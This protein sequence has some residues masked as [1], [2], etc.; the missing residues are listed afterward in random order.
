MRSL[1]FQLGSHDANSFSE[2]QLSLHGR[3]IDT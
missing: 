3:D 2:R 1:Q